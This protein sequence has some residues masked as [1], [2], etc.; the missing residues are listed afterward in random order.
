MRSLRSPRPDRSAAL[1]HPDLPSL[2]P[3]HGLVVALALALVAC[4]G[5]SADPT[6]PPQGGPTRTTLVPDGNAGY[7]EARTSMVVSDGSLPSWVFDDFTF[8]RDGTIGTV[9]W[10]GIYCVQAAGSSAPSPTASGFTVSFY[11]D[12]GGRPVVGTP[13]Q[14]ATYALAQSNQRFIR[15]VGALTCGS[16]TPT[17]WSFYN[18]EVELATPFQAAAGTKYWLSIQ[19]NTPSYAVYFGWRDGTPDNHLSLQLF[20]GDYTAWDVDRAY[21]LAP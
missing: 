12:Q 7:V 1:P 15:N 20:D 16:A 13:L 2:S 10:Q 19:A 17:E 21:S 6:P 5:D 9:G 3:R 8:D 11:A 4:G 14:T 18:Y